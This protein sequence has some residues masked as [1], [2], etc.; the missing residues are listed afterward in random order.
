MKTLY[1]DESGFTG[2]NLLDPI[3][4]IFTIASTDID[5]KYAEQILLESFP[6]YKGDEFKFTNIWP[7]TNRSGFIK[8]GEHLGGLKENAFTWM[9]DK[10]FAVLT[11][12]VDFLIEPYITNSGYNFYAD[13][14]CWKYANYIHFG[15]EQF[16]PPELYQSLVDSYQLFSRTP[17]PDNLRRL[18]VTLNLM[19]SSSTE[20]VN[21]FLEQMAIGADLFH[22]FHNIDTFKGSDELQLT[23][24]LAVVSHWRKNAADDFEVVHDATSNFFRRKELW[25]KITNNNVPKQ[26]H[27][28]G[29]GT[30]VEYPLRVVSTRSENSKH[31]R[32]IQ[33]CDLL[34][35]IVSRH[36]YPGLDAD[37]RK[38]LDDVIEAG[39]K[40]IDYNGIRPGLDFP[41]F[42][43]KKA[44]GPDA[45]DQMTQIIFGPHNAN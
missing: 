15:F 19:A 10:K 6:K 38:F 14:F 32:S 4:P 11:K 3:Q 9:I 39:M 5:E 45:V 20:P 31:N 42:P 24:M 21:L 18:Q 37:T 44:D 25:D 23:S 41:D 13:G 2:Y 36:F 35:G 1:F 30:F 8:F 27:P 29:D 12:I 17:T 22:K 28:L 16:A 33:F 26:L 34:A 43:P 40:N 7:S